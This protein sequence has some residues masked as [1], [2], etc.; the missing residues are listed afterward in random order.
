MLKKSTLIKDL[1]LKNQLRMKEESL[2]RIQTL[3]E[4]ETTRWWRRT[5]FFL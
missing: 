4:R 1:I 2:L 5:W 3:T